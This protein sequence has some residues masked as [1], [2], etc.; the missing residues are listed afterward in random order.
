MLPAIIDIEASGFGRESYP[1][2]V[3]VVL[4]DRKCHCF[5][6]RPA[7]EWTFWDREAE[8]IHGISRNTLLDKGLPPEQVA[9]E[10]NQLL[11]GSRIYTDAWSYDI[12]WLGKLFELT[13]LPQLFSLESLRYLM[14]EQQAAL[15][16]QTKDQVMEELHLDR[17]RASSDA[18][19][20]QETFR[21]TRAES[22]TG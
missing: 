20:L 10:L 17:H 5:I 3:G 4:P 7:E 2:E 21:R 16:H 19:I 8:K 18:K 6:I 1:I 13:G 9:S 11:H 12:S 22:A 15:W 14:S